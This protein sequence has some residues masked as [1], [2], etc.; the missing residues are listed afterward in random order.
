MN[1][2]KVV[3]TIGLGPLADRMGLFIAVAS[4]NGEMSFNITSCRRTLPDIEFFIECIR[5]SFEELSEIAKNFDAKKINKKTTKDVKKKA[6]KVTSSKAKSTTRN[7]TT[8]KKVT[9]KKRSGKKVSTK[10]VSAKKT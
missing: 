8:K 2:A 9:T 4:Y 7:K 3:R 1:G 5:D 6:K 10:K